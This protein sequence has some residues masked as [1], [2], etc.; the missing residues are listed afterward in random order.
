M[1]EI[2][3]VA[4]KS[5]CPNLIFKEENHLRE[6]VVD[7]W[8]QKLTLNYENAQLSMSLPHTVIGSVLKRRNLRSASNFVSKTIL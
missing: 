7:I 6:N 2:E 5:C 3:N 4:N 8:S 1:I